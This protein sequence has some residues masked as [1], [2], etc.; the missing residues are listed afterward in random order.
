MELNGFDE[1]WYRTSFPSQQLGRHEFSPPK[2]LGKVNDL[3]SGISD[4]PKSV[5]PQKNAGF[6]GDFKHRVSLLT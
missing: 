2:I 5:L 6:D 3:V 4:E 1:I